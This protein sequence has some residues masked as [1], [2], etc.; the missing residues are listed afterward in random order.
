MQTCIFL[1]SSEDSV[2]K[3]E[4]G[5]LPRIQYHSYTVRGILYTNQTWGIAPPVYI[6]IREFCIQ[7][8]P[9]ES[10]GRSRI[11]SYQGILYTKSEG[12]SPRIHSDHGILYTKSEGRIILP[13]SGFLWE[14]N[15]CGG[16]KFLYTFS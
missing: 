13:S 4:G 2:Y 9:G 15:S 5:S 11:H 14:D 16:I 1:I 10:L 8:R 6:L 12:E 3:S 7:T